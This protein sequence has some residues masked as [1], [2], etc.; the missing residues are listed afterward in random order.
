MKV[1][2][3]LNK[4]KRFHAFAPKRLS[5]TGNKQ[6]TRNRSKY[7]S[8]LRQTWQSAKF[9]IQ[10]SSTLRRNFINLDALAGNKFKTSSYLVGN[11]KYQ[12]E[13]NLHYVNFTLNNKRIIKGLY[14]YVRRT[15]AHFW[16]RLK[17]SL[18]LISQVNTNFIAPENSD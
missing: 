3:K 18:G 16:K 15:S 4:L 5:L 9:A 13:L 8:T 12:L 7:A 2:V 14:L 10:F 11:V 6:R 17:R 1:T